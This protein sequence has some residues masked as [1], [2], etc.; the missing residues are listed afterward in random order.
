MKST[1]HPTLLIPTI[2]LRLKIALCA[3]GA[4]GSLLNAYGHFRSHLPSS[5]SSHHSRPRTLGHEKDACK[6][7]TSVGLRAFVIKFRPPPRN[8]IP[9]A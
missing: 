7:V 5:L 2:A 1:L 6:T 9:L 8:S 3:L 4:T